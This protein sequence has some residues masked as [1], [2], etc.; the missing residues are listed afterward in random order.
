MGYDSITSI[1]SP[2]GSSGADR[3]H[4]FLKEFEELSLE[5]KIVL[6][7]WVTDCKPSA[8]GLPGHGDFKTFMQDLREL[9]FKYM[10]FIDCFVKSDMLVVETFTIEDNIDEL[11]LNEMV[12]FGLTEWSPKLMVAFQMIELESVT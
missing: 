2:G 4:A 5:Y 6:S 1:K 11:R 3:T 9:Y 7:G 12:E 8:L 10:L